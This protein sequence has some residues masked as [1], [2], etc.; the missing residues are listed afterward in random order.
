M[1]AERPP[2]DPRWRALAEAAAPRQAGVSPRRKNLAIIERTTPIL[3]DPGW[4]R[5]SSTLK[6]EGAVTLAD[7]AADDPPA[8]RGRGPPA[9]DPLLTTRSL[10]GLLRTLHE[11]SISD[12]DLKAANIMIQGDP[13]TGEAA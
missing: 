3:P 13:A 7:Y 10:A 6:V 1:A 5:S 2:A 4:R 9:G 12:R 11:R 8:A